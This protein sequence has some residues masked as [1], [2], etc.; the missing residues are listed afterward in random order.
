MRI[1]II[2]AA[3]AFCSV[4]IAQ[5][6]V[7]PDGP[8]EGPLRY[9][10]HDMATN[11]GHEVAGPPEYGPTI[12]YS[13]MTTFSGYYAGVGGFW[14]D[15]LNMVSGGMVT[16]FSFI[17]YDPVTDPLQQLTTINTFFWDGYV[18]GSPIAGFTIGGLPGDGHWIIGV[19][20]EGS[21]YE[22]AAPDYVL[23]GLDFSTCDSTEAGWSMWDPPTIGTSG[24]AFYDVIAQGWYWFGGDP[25]ANFGAEVAIPEPGAIAMIGVGLVGLL[26]LR[27]RK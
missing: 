12:V 16:G 7:T 13:N 22:F 25:V 21:G 11:T 24:D 27:R 6:L 19:N 14:A 17:Y 23:Y 10:I 1:P 18:G 8:V 3:L 15:D 4:A 20:L 26:A 2:A 5:E 9:W